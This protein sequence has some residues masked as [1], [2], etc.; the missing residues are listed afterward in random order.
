MAYFKL[1][2]IIIISSDSF[3]SSFK[4]FNFSQNFPTAAKLSDFSETFQLRSVLSNFARFFSTSQGSFQLKQKLS[5]YRISNSSFF[6]LPFQLHVSLS[7]FQSLKIFE[8]C[9]FL[10]TEVTLGQIWGQ[11]RSSDIRKSNIF[12]NTKK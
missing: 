6:K 9:S 12:S 8:Y 2:L 7:F 11:T 5:N 10:F 3:P 1:L 4:L